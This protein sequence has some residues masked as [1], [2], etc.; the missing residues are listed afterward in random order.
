[1]LIIMIIVIVLVALVA[2]QPTWVWKKLNRASTDRG[3]FR[4]SRCINKIWWVHIQLNY[5]VRKA[6]FLLHFDIYVPLRHKVMFSRRV[7][8]V[9]R[10]IGYFRN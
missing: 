4:A 1:M 5:R 9:L 7:Y 3:H 6:L 2:I 10:K 8:P